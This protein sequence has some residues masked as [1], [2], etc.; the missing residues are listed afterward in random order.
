M[1]LF[2][3]RA[4]LLTHVHNDPGN[5]VLTA[6]VQ[7][8]IGQPHRDLMGMNPLVSFIGIRPLHHLIRTL[9]ISKGVLTQNK[10]RLMLFGTTPSELRVSRREAFRLAHHCEFTLKPLVSLI[11]D[12][13]PMLCHK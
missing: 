4:T 1:C 5:V 12:I 10:G 7:R 13:V 6:L 11:R 3:T 8:L 9:L 2:A